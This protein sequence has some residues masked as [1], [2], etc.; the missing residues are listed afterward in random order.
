MVLKYPVCEIGA[1]FD[2][3]DN[4]DYKVIISFARIEKY[5]SQAELQTIIACLK[6]V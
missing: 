5:S 1:T 2:F 3:L 4:L 6:E